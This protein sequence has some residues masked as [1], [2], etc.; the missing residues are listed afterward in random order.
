M[1]FLVATACW[2]KISRNEWQRYWDDENIKG[3]W[4]DSLLFEEDIYGSKLNFLERL[5]YIHCNP[6]IRSGAGVKIVTNDAIQQLIQALN[7]EARPLPTLTDLARLEAIERSV[8]KIT[9]KDFPVGESLKVIF[10]GHPGTGKT[11]RLIHIG[12]SHAYAGAKVMFVCFNKTLASDIRR[13]LSFHKNFNDLECKFEVYDIFQL[14]SQCA[15]ALRFSWENNMDYDEWGQLIYDDMRDLT[16][17][18]KLP[19]FDTILV[20]EAQDMADWQTDFIMLYGTSVSGICLAVGRGQE[21]YGDSARPNQWLL[22]LKRNGA[23]EKVCRRNFRNTLPNFMF[24]RIFYD[25][26]PKLDKISSTLANFKNKQLDLDFDRANGGLPKRIFIDESTLPDMLD[27]CYPAFQNELMTQACLDIIK[28]EYENFKDK[29]QPIDLLILVPD[30]KSTYHD[31]VIAA[32][33]KFKLDTGIG[34][35]D[36]TNEDL[37]RVVAETGKLRITTFHSS[38]GLEGARVI[39]FGL[40][41]LPMLSRRINF[42]INKLAYIVLSRAVFD[43]TLVMRN[44]SNSEIS[45]F[46]EMA[47]YEINKVIESQQKR[48]TVNPIEFH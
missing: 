1:P 9:L 42:N 20:D 44:L 8:N 38:R 34:F 10:S 15:S 48:G 35:I 23:L 25:A 28:D 41:Q 26:F 27:P 3:Q 33:Y 47:L 2:P 24:S 29:H 37:R 43:T 18:A 11:F 32:L 4:A 21:L 12:F 36:Y 5:N 40:E 22:D 14:V 46:I 16:N 13:I 17:A 7:P 31:W 30:T 6:P 45:K 19:K 39:I